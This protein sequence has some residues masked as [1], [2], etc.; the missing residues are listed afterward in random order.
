MKGFWLAAVAAVAVGVLFAGGVA[1]AGGIEVA[2]FD[3]PEQEARYF[4]LIGG[5]RCLVC[6]NQ[7]LAESNAP[8]AKDM[9]VA[10]RR[11]LR[12]GAT[13]AEVIEFVVG[14]YGDFVLYRPP[15]AARTFILWFAPF[16][17]VVVALLLTPFFVTRRRVVLSGQDKDTAQQLLRE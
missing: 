1:R 17:F 16:L 5:M 14:R 10:I 11:L 2:H 13:D 3:A 8:L 12:D 15:L 7:T 4:N 6:Q 9:R